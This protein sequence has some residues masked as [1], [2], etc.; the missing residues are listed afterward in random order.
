MLK[1]KLAATLIAASIALSGCSEYVQRAIDWTAAAIYVVQAGL[2]TARAQAEAACA[3]IGRIEYAAE[4]AATQI[5][6]ACSKWH[7][8]VVSVRK[9][10]EAVC[11]NL[12]KLNDGVIGNYISSVGSSLKQARDAKPDGC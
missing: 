9:G 1:L 10:V 11:V 12:P 8:R 7:T 5:G 4:V 3:E 2:D 6:S